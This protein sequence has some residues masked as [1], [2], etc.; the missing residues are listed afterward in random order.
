MMKR[1][2]C[3]YVVFFDRKYRLNPKPTF[4]SLAKRNVVTA[5]NARRMLSVPSGAPL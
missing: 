1:G 2:G 5:A 3:S 4:P